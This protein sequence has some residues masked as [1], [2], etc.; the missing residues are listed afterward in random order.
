MSN[1]NYNIVYHKDKL[2]GFYAIHEV[3]HICGKTL[4]QDSP[5][6]VG[7]NKEEILQNLSIIINDVNKYPTIIKENDNSETEELIKLLESRIEKHN[8][9]L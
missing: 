9:K 4:I 5:I 2:G 8:Q 1:W 6:L 3:Y 7:S